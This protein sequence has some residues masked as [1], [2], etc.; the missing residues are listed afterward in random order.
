M[1][2]DDSTGDDDGPAERGD[3]QPAENDVGDPFEALDPET[4]RDREGD[5]FA[6]LDGDGSA[7][8]RRPGADSGPPGADRRP[9]GESTGSSTPRRPD[10]ESGSDAGAPGSSPAGEE[11]PFDYV[12]ERGE[13]GDAADADRPPEDRSGSSPVDVAGDP[14]GDVDVSRGDPFESADT[15]FEQVDT[16]GADPDEIW[17]R[18][19]GETE[20]VSDAGSGSGTESRAGPDREPGT[21]P[22][23]ERDAGREVVA[24]PKHS[25]CERCEHFSAPP[26]VACGHEGTD[27]LEFVGTDEV[28]V[29]NCPVV[30]ERRLLGELE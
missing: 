16:G 30:A 22:A 4:Y 11:D 19:T 10:G 8:D 6:D 3:D 24:V 14:F 18:F 5:P 28:R 21:S 12:G 26:D 7:G 2:G 1:T 27:I 13:G 29:S 9:D 17:E 25:F 15:P 20:S 23:A